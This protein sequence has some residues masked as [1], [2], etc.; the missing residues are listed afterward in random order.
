MEKV[1][2]FNREE[3]RKWLQVN[4]KKE[5]KVAVILH[6]KHTSKKAPTHRELIEEAICFGWI[7]TT[8][9]R[10]DENRYIRNFS[11]RNEKSRWS[12]NTIKYAS[13]LVKQKKMSSFGLKKYQ[14]GLRRPAYDFGIPKYP[15]M[16]EELKK[17]LDKNKKGK[18]NF[19]KYAPS[20]KR[21]LYRQ[22]L[23]GKTKETRLKRVKKIVEF[24]KLGKK[25]FFSTSQKVNS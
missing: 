18:E 6:K 24:S 15:S 23:L 22:I 13:E 21:M 25:D 19:E 20:F 11:K 14:E 12:N 8:L 16:P 3:F 7:D 5:Q 2:I 17:A 10:L 1:E 9:K 4:H